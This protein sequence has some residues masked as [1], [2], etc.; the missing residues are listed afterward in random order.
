MS[1]TE[2]ITSPNGG[3]S[4]Q[5]LQDKLRV[6]TTS[7]QT[8]GAYELFELTGPLDSG[9]PPH[10]HPWGESYFILD[11]EVEVLLADRRI[12]ATSGFFVNIPSATVHTY[13]IA[14]PHARFLVLTQGAGALEFFTDLDREIDV[15]NLDIDRVIAVAARHGVIPVSI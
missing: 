3:I 6:L 12:V 1:A 8:G 9:P 14:S 5:V 11:G 15:K 2:L 10:Y 4:L 13:R 7:T